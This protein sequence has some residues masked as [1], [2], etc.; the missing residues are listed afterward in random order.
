MSPL[1]LY[2][3]KLLKVANALAINENCCCTTLCNN[4]GYNCFTVI[5]DGNLPNNI[6]FNNLPLQLLVPD[7]ITVNGETLT[8]SNIGWS[9]SPQFG[10]NEAWINIV[11]GH[12]TMTFGAGSHERF[13]LPVDWTYYG[14]NGIS[15]NLEIPIRYD[16]NKQAF[17]IVENFTA[18]S[19]HDPAYPPVANQLVFS[20]WDY[21]GPFTDLLST[22]EVYH[23]PCK[24]NTNLMNSATLEGWDWEINPN[25]P[26]Q[27][28]YP[29]KLDNMKSFVNRTHYRKNIG[30]RG[31]FIPTVG[32]VGGQLLGPDCVGNDMYDFFATNAGQG[33]LIQGVGVSIYG[34]TA[35]NNDARLFF[36]GVPPTNVGE[37]YLNITCTGGAV[38]PD[39]EGFFDCGRQVNYAAN[40]IAVTGSWGQLANES[41]LLKSKGTV[42]FS[43]QPRPQSYFTLTFNIN[44]ANCVPPQ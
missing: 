15:F 18:S 44:N 2:D 10:P 25:L 36:H 4:V 35:N 12:T 8:L 41:F 3:G 5:D 21:G 7:E 40:D 23:L 29:E 38:Q 17:V 39:P 31:V 30:A 1:Y 6:D 43:T 22:P 32:P 28:D 24:R 13:N 27:P 9:T 34:P 14:I 16:P 11:G 26:Q 33:T 19:Y 20:L 42:T 37:V